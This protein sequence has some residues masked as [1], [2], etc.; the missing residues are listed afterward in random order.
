MYR[1]SRF[2]RNRLFRLRFGAAIVW[3]VVAGIG[4]DAPP[5][6][7]PDAGAELAVRPPESVGM[8]GR[9]L[10]QI[11]G[12]VAAAI[13]DALLPGAV[14][15][16]AKD[17]AVVWR[18]AYGH[19]AVHPQPVPMTVD[20]IFD[21]ASVT[22]VIATATS[23]M[24]LA[25]RGLIDTTE[26]VTACIPEYARNGKG[27]T[28]IEQLLTHTAGLPPGNP[29]SDY[30][31]GPERAIERF[32]AIEPAQP[33]VS[34]FRYS[35]VGY[36]VLGEIVG[37]VSGVPLDAFARQA[38]LVRLGMAHTTFNPPQ[39][40]WP[41]VAP[42][43]R[44]DGQWILGEV[45]DPH[46]HLL[47]GVAG[48]AGLFST[49][50]DLARY[51][52]MIL[53]DGRVPND[54]RQLLSPETVRRM[55]RIPAEATHGRGLSFDV[56]TAYSSPRGDV[57]VAG[58]S[59]G[60]TGFTGASLWIS[61]PDRTFVIILSNRMHPN[62][63]GDVRGLRRK[64]ATVVASAI[65]REVLPGIDVLERDG[66]APLTGRKVG[67]ITNHTGRTRSGRSLV[68]LLHAAGNVEL[69]SVFSPEHGFK[70]VLDE[71][72]ADA[73][74]DATGVPIYS[75]YGETRR[76]TRTMLEGIDTL[77]FDVQD[78][79]TRFYTYITTMGYAME[80]AARHGI[81]FV[82]LDR[83]NPIS[84][85]RPAGPVAGADKLS[86]TAYHRLPV[87]HAMTVGELARLFN[88]ERMIGA[89]L[90]VVKVE[91]WRRGLFFDATGL[92]WVNPSPNMRS[93][94][95][96]IL[97][98]AIGLLEMTNLSVGRG[99]DRPFEHFGAPWIDGT[100]LTAALNKLD[101]PGVRF[102]ATQFT[103]DA[104][105]FKGQACRGVD[106]HLIDRY[107]FAPARTAL[108]IARVLE[109][110]YGEQW[111]HEKANRLL[112][113]EEAMTAWQQADT[114][115]AVA[116]TWNQELKAFEQVRDKYLIY[117]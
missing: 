23:V 60:H 40:W 90:H 52:Q 82:V 43:D 89:D 48:H 46:A 37:R 42:Q 18:K 6:A 113:N 78:I 69:V 101:L 64:V 87:R 96:A 45:H 116:Q 49:V 109:R 98:P 99:T 67:V 94:T 110:L 95:E 14:V 47:G 84:G 29:R 59:F 28:T 76:P 57:F 74:D 7:I 25:E 17:G 85:I 91:N 30:D 83:P 24:L 70:G 51:C 75:L 105:K 108:G 26:K 68:A 16:V 38:V 79:G 1:V 77:V 117:E 31:D 100:A 104:S 92:E 55:T 63:T 112:A 41:R 34:R 107:D 93:L 97:Y 21:V 81:R 39:T 73:H 5:K 12:L 56:D 27:E 22:K 111:K 11:D 15:L 4:C 106:V 19:R 62:G 102:T 13:D 8:D 61:P 65:R 33:I 86:F 58:E 66:L 54:D 114:L 88:R 115:D 103:P 3:A 20:T 32:F 71:A 2:P 72:V 50:D 35:D 10:A 36:I 53:N 80:E 44:R 9:I